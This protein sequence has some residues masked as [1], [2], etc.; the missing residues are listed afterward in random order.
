VRWNALPPTLVL[1]CRTSDDPSREGKARAVRLVE[2]DDDV[3]AY[4]HPVDPKPTRYSR[5]KN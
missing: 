2:L 3:L 1:N 4:Q 5:A